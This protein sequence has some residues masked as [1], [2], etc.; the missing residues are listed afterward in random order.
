[1]IT[2][3][4]E[5]KTADGAHRLRAELRPQ[6]IRYII[7]SAKEEVV[8]IKDDHHK[9]SWAKEKQDQYHCKFTEW[10]SNGAYDLTNLPTAPCNEEFLSDRSMRSHQ[11]HCNACIALR[12]T[13]SKHSEV[14]T[15]VPAIEGLTDF[16]VAGMIAVMKTR[17]E[18]CMDMA[19]RYDAAVQALLSL[20]EVDERKRQLEEDE[21]K[22]R[23]ALAY[24]L[25]EQ[26]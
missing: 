2:F 23:Q 19:Q 25:K 14:K 10:S 7:A 22:H 3:M 20:S 4:V 24:F 6:H 8:F 16:S 9:V 18:E 26:E 13:S 21:A 12:P 15:V 1:M 11:A 17:S 5:H